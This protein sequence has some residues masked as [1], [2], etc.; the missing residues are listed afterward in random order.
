ME[1]EFNRTPYK[2]DWTITRAMSTSQPRCTQ[3]SARRTPSRWSF[4]ELKDAFRGT[5]MPVVLGYEELEGLSD[6]G[7]WNCTRGIL[8]L[9]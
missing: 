1:C 2:K 3:E 8:L 4:G 5:R 6:P 7:A 9:G